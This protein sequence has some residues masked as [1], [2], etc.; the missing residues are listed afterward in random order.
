MRGNHTDQ[1]K[2]VEENLSV[3]I[4]EH[5][6]RWPNFVE[7]FE[8]RNLVAHGSL[9]VN[10]AYLERCQEAR[11]KLNKDIVV[12]ST[13]TLT[14]RYLSRAISILMEFGMLLIFTLW[15]KHVPNSDQEAFSCLNDCCYT[16]I[17]K[18]R[19]IAARNV[20]NFCIFKQKRACSENV[21]RMMIINL[22]NAYKKLKDEAECEKVLSNFDWSATKIEFQLCIGSLRGDVERVVSLMPIAAASNAITGNAFRDWPVLDWVRDDPT[23]QEAFNRVYGEPM[24]TEVSSTSEM[25]SNAGS[26]PAED[27]TGDSSAPISVTRH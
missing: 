11:Y 20:L 17:S 26:G 4:I 22:A 27:T 9:I 12:G 8:R 7:L 16:L 13:L 19:Y 25:T 10:D 23:I 2:F 1:V 6:E 5:Y 24:W 21:H 14:N 15:R 18:K 3:K